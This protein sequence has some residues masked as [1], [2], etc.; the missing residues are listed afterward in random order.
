MLTT[1]SPLKREQNSVILSHW[2]Q[3]SMSINQNSL[4]SACQAY[5][6]IDIDTMTLSGDLSLKKTTS[7]GT[8]QER[9]EVSSYVCTQIL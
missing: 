6:D 9:S 3:N 4:S 2:V 7:K 8:Q 1:E 5:Y